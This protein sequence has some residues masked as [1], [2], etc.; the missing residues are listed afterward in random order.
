MRPKWDR[1]DY[2]EKTIAA[3][4]E[5]TSDTWQSKPRG[6]AAMVDLNRFSPSLE[7]L[8][9]LS[10]WQG[11]VTF[12]SVKRR[13][14][15]VI[16]TTKDAEIVWP[17]T[18]DLGSFA[19]SQAI[20]SDVTNIWIPTP[21]HREIRLHW[22]PAIHLL[23]QIAAA[24][25]QRLEPPLKEEVRDLIRLMWRSAGQPTSKDSGGFIEFV[26]AVAVARRNPTGAIPPCVFVA[27][28]HVWV[29]VPSFRLWLSIPALTNK[30]FP[31][32]DIRNGLMLL[33][34]IYCENL[35]RGHQGD[36]ETACLWRGPLD[37]L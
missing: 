9:S 21:P 29:H 24:D 2:R 4:I 25:G 15:M 34:F 12:T 10:V 28:E 30:L 33:G 17:S 37:V 3:A 19:K 36:S 14:P 32:A 7:L 22:D 26:R 27:E 8:N 31:L 16:A 1:A 18:A 6:P 20:I 35:S 5:R 13:G 23:L 11:R